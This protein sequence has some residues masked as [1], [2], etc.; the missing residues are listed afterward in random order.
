MDQIICVQESKL[1]NR[2]VVEA[3]IQACL[4]QEALTPEQVTVVLEA[5]K[6]HSSENIVDRNYTQRM[7]VAA[8]RAW[9]IMPIERLAIEQVVLSDAFRDYR[10]KDVEIASQG[11]NETILANSLELS[12]MSDYFQN[13]FTSSMDEGQ[14]LHHAWSGS[15][16]AE[17]WNIVLSK[18][19]VHVT[20]QASLVAVEVLLENKA[21]S[22]DKKITY[23][24][25]HLRPS[26]ESAVRDS[27]D[28]MFLAELSSNLNETTA[29]DHYIRAMKYDPTDRSPYMSHFKDR[30][31]KLLTQKISSLEECTQILDDV[32]ED[33]IKNLLAR[34]LKRTQDMLRYAMM[35]SEE[36]FAILRGDKTSSVLTH[37]ICGDLLIER[38]PGNLK[39]F[40]A[41]INSPGAR[42]GK[43]KAGLFKLLKKGVTKVF[44]DHK[45]NNNPVDPAAVNRAQIW[46]LNFDLVASQITRYDHLDIRGL[47]LY[48]LIWLL[49]TIAPYVTH[50]NLSGFAEEDDI[51]LW[52][53]D[54]PKLEELT[55]A[56]CSL[57]LTFIGNSKPLPSLRRIDFSDSPRLKAFVI[58]KG[59]QLTHLNVRNCANWGDHASLEANRSTL[60]WL[61]VVGCN[62]DFLKSVNWMVNSSLVIVYHSSDNVLKVG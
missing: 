45:V 4:T 49:D 32:P 7:L 8:Q 41:P 35:P 36:L 56:G 47:E 11:G 13:V 19:F 16:I 10:P 20:V 15:S 12:K 34:G 31:V 38:L 22:V 9:H 33:C 50:L 55:M 44:K 23:E 42:E 59:L 61:D 3:A 18:P 57:D 1:L 14:T 43:K 53:R 29:L 24:L 26:Q 39:Y 21:S 54:F 48:Q 40:E 46:L 58:G 62:P 37:Q 52:S 25:L 5:L 17:D 30:C 27:I 60:Q 6:V 51:P 28:K 2:E